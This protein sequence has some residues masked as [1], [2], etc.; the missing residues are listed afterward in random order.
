MIFPQN[1]LQAGQEPPDR[2]GNYIPKYPLLFRPGSPFVQAGLRGD[3]HKDIGEV[4]RG[5]NGAFGQVRAAIVGKCFFIKNPDRCNPAV[6]GFSACTSVPRNIRRTYPESPPQSPADRHT[7]SEKPA[8]LPKQPFRDM[9]KRGT[10]MIKYKKSAKA[11]AVIQLLQ[12]QSQLCIAA[13]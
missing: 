10:K 6:Q 9:D 5:D 13:C 3:G 4:G 1:K 12:E 2:P 11:K 8:G 7:P